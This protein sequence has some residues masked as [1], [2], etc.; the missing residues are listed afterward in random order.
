MEGILFSITPDSPPSSLRDDL[1]KRKWVRLPSF[2]K[3]LKRLT[4][5]L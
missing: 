2:G 1:N 4:A 3:P 5:Q